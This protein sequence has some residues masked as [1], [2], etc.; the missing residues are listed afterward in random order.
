VTSARETLAVVDYPRFDRHRASGAHPECPERLEAA[1]A[2]R[3]AAVDPA[4]L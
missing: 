2:G 1:R 4:A 3:R